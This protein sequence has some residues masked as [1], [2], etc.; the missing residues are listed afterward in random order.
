MDTY[1][2]LRSADFL[3]HSVF[4]PSSGTDGQ[5]IAQLSKHWQHFVYVD[6]GT[7][8]QK[9]LEHLNRGFKGYLTGFKKLDFVQ[10]F[11]LSH[12]LWL[13]EMP[14]HLSPPGRIQAPY[15]YHVILYRLPSF[16]SS[17]GPEKIEL[18]YCGA[19]ALFVFRHLYTC[20][21]LMPAA[22]TIIS[23][24]YGFG[25]GW[26]NYEDPNSAFGKLVNWEKVEVIKK[27]PFQKIEKGP[28]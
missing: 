17:H 15:V 6:Y 3:Q 22:L 20:Q 1:S 13:S 2:W 23:P 8:E 21:S 5:P 16:T 7:P 28:S 26:V 27:I 12:Q 18:L 19:E 14:L 4:Y 24:G 25:G 9:F 10:L 11:G